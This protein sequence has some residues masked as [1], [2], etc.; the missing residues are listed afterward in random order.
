MA[1]PG[2]QRTNRIADLE[3]RHMAGDFLDHPRALESENWT[4]TRRGRVAAFALREVRAIHGAGLDTDTDL[5]VTQ[6][7]ARRI[8]PHQSIAVNFNGF[9]VVAPVSAMLGHS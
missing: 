1:T 8:G 5:A 3:T 4:R 6:G 2:Q 7:R 9:H